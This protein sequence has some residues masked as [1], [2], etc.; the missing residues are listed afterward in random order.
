MKI[1]VASGKGGTGKTTVAT[2][3][4]RLASEA[5]LTTAYL[6]CDVEAPN[7]H[8]FLAPEI[9]DRQ[10]ISRLVPEV[11][12]PDCTLCGLCGDICEF[13]AIVCLGQKVLVFPE[14]CHSCGGCKLVCPENAILERAH[15]M[16]IVETGRSGR[17]R[18][19][20][21]RLHVGEAS[22]PPVI[23]AVKQS[24][25]PAEL[26]ICDAP[27]GTAC[28]MIETTR[29]SDFVLLVTEPTPF[30][31]HDL[32]LAWNVIK[33]SRMNCGVVINRALAG[34]T[35]TRR[36]C[37]QSRIPILAEIPD[38]L[39]V[40][41]AYSEGRLAIEAV[42]GMRRSFAHL[43]L[44]LEKIAPG[45]RLPEKVRSYLN[46]LTQTG[47]ASVFQDQPELPRPA[48]SL[49]YLAKPKEGSRPA[50]GRPGCAPIAP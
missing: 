2:N 42:P 39:A 40:A 20:Q 46:P 19:V 31:L 8:L 3:L 44:E 29:G 18:I 34:A 12:A 16:G 5:G 7:G 22:S 36:F 37:Q 24:A 10:E 35:E 21:G 28:P 6:D 45:W 23:R 50:D 26:L 13:N 25:P 11:Q 41:E 48:S 27:P 32:K 1:V 9:E 4:A 33:S 47:N 15:P 43:L 17:L 14:L 38:I 30:G 49:C